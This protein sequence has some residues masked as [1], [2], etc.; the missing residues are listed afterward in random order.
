MLAL[1]AGDDGL[2]IVRVFLSLSFFLSFVFLCSVLVSFS[3]FCSLIGLALAWICFSDS[4]NSTAIFAVLVS[5]WCFAP[6]NWQ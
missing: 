5:F 3:P 4:Q 2:F 6:G 1:E